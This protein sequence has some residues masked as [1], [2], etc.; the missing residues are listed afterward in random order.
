MKHYGQDRTGRLMGDAAILQA[1]KTNE[2]D[3]VPAYERASR[4][5]DVIPAS[6]A[7][8]SALGIGVWMWRSSGMLGTIPCTRRPRLWSSYCNA[9]FPRP[10]HQL[11]GSV[12]G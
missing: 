3:T 2:D 8:R 10:E 7:I 11:E 6:I 1:L 12:R 4:H 9:T 5:E